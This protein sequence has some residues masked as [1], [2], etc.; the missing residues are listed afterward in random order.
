MAKKTP[1][2]DP[3]ELP[4]SPDEPESIRARR[5]LMLAQ[6]KGLLTFRWPFDTRTGTNVEKTT[7]ELVRVG[8]IP[9]LP[10]EPGVYYFMW[11]KADD[12]GMDPTDEAGRRPVFIPEGEVK[13]AV[14][15]LAVKAGVSAEFVYREGMLPGRS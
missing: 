1:P 9:K 4:I 8:F 13:P 6:N 3:V 15:M 14:L 11:V 2:P 5:M 7:A 10:P 12:D